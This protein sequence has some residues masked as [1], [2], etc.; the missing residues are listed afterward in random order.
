LLKFVDQKDY[1][2]L[3]RCGPNRSKKKMTAKRAAHNEGRPPTWKGKEGQETTFRAAER[4]AKIG[5][6]DRLSRLPRRGKHTSKRGGIGYALACR[7]EK[8]CEI[9]QKERYVPESVAASAEQSRL[10]KG[11]AGVGGTASAW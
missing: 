2:H 10:R 3:K 9:A 11:V 5:A 1:E 8:G 4:G 6:F 7:R